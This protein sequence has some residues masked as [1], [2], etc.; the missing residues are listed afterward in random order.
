M[1][2]TA[3]RVPLLSDVVNYVANVVVIVVVVVVIFVV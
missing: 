2:L 3:V 1:I